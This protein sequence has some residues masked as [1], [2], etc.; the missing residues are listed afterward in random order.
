MVHHYGNYI[1]E[2]DG[3]LYSNTSYEG[4]RYPSKSW[5]TCFG[6]GYGKS[7][8][9]GYDSSTMRT[10]PVT[11]VGNNNDDEG[12]AYGKDDDDDDWWRYDWKKDYMAKKSPIKEEAQDM[13]THYDSDDL[14]LD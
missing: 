4:Y 7:Y 2:T 8:G 5:G 9:S 12:F 1:T 3:C 11:A 10:I 14:P 13:F 6:S